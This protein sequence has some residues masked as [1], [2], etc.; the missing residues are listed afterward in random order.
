MCVVVCQ[1]MVC[2]HQ[3]YWVSHRLQLSLSCPRDAPLSRCS[4]CLHT[5]RNQP[6]RLFSNALHSDCVMKMNI[7]HNIVVYVRNTTTL[8]DWNGA[9]GSNAKLYIAISA[10]KSHDIEYSVEMHHLNHHWH[11]LYYGWFLYYVL[12]FMH[13]QPG[14]EKKVPLHYSKMTIHWFWPFSWFCNKFFNLLELLLN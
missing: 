11:F 13:T 14:P 5:L 8:W 7:F 12:V 2:W 1:M 9:E 6:V 4:Q 3:I 10:A